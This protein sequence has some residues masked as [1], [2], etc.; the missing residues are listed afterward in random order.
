M[1]E[2]ERHIQKTVIHLKNGNTILYPTDTIWG[3]G[4]DAT[5]RNAIHKVFEIKLRPDAKSVLLLAS[6]V[7]MLHKYLTTIPVEASALIAV[8]DRPLTIIYPGAKNLPS[9]LIA[10]DGSIGIR[11]THDKF[12]NGVI[13]KL[14]KPLVSTS[15]NFSGSPYPESFTEIDPKLMK[16]VDYVVRWRNHDPSLNI[17]SKIIKIDPSGKTTIIRE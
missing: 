13:S 12:C 14:G 2:L 3:I 7:D 10:E 5:N 11:V 4:C 15:A 17:P 8:E 1:T 6:S 9:E 16:Q